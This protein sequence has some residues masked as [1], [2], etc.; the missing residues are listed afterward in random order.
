MYEIE[1][2]RMIKTIKTNSG[3]TKNSVTEFK[4]NQSLFKKQRHM[5]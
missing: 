2:C 4:D 3:G 1:M 5:F